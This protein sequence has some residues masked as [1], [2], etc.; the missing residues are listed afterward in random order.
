MNRKLQIAIKSVL[1]GA[2]LLGS[3]GAF[4]AGTVAIA[5]NWD[6]NGNMLGADSMIQT[7]S[8]A[9]ASN[10]S[11]TGNA[12]ALANDGWAHTGTW[13]TF[14]VTAANQNVT[15][16]TQILSGNFNPAFTLYASGNTP[17]NGGTPSPGEVSTAGG[18]APH[19]FNQVGQVGSDGIGWASSPA[20]NGPTGNLLETLAY[21][22]SGVASTAAQTGYGQTINY[23]V[24]QV[25]TDNVFFSGSVGGSVSAT[26]AK[27]IFNDLAMGYYT[28]FVGGAN[29]AQTLAS[30]YQITVS[31]VSS[32]P[33]PGAVY[34]FGSALAGFVA[35]ARKRQKP[36]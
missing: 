28:I 35:S 26:D 24:N 17:F 21:A 11:W 36:A 30:T 19:D 13:L 22:N 1:A 31:S 18:N 27:L 33:L 23:G 32:V 34:L 9:M 14:D 29:A 4:A 8:K 2:A 3:T 12:A 6:V 15:V 20:I 5:N 10:K 16:D 25:A 7:V